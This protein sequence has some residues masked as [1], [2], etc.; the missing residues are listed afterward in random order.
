MMAFDAYD[1]IALWERD[2]GLSVADKALLLLAL[3]RPGVSQQELGA[4]PI[5]ARDRALFEMRRALFGN[6]LEGLAVCSE[7][8]E[9]LEMELPIA[10]FLAGAKPAEPTDHASITAGGAEVRFR[11]PTTDDAVLVS[12]IRDNS[13]ARQALVRCCI[14]NATQGGASVAPGDLDSEIIARVSQEMEALDP[15]SEIRLTLACSACEHTQSVLLEVASYLW[16]ELVSEAERL[17]EDVR[18]LAREYGWREADILAM[19]G[20]RRQ[21][22]LD[23]RQA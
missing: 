11:L 14:V 9:Q 22:Y 10:D 2:Q 6:R 23:R 16:Q 3:A 4:M 17:L 1:L 8:G 21:F 7:C 20:R 13:D 15:L 5:G 18:I 19:S 12:R